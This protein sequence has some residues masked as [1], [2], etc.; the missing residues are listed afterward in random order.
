LNCEV[1][2]EAISVF[3]PEPVV[4][5]VKYVAD[6]DANTGYIIGFSSYVIGDVIGFTIGEL[7][8]PIILKY[9]DNPFPV[10]ETIFLSTYALLVSSVSIVD[11]IE[12]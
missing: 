8:V 10:Y 4:C 6:G 7:I 11:S 3:V 2:N 12:H 5:R 1:I 9:I